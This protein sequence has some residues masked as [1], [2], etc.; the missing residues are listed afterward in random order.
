[1]KLIKIFTLFIFLLEFLSLS[2]TMNYKYN[3]VDYNDGDDDY[4]YQYDFD[5]DNIYDDNNNY[6][7]QYEYIIDGVYQD[8]E[9]IMDHPKPGNCD[10]V[11]WTQSG[12]GGV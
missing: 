4:Y 6:E 11:E 1:M 9:M 7:Y 2:S 10:W 12:I 8:N 3:G 5:S